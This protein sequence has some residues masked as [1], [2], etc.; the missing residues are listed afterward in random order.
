VGS[1]EHALTELERLAGRPITSVD[2]LLRFIAAT[3]APR[4]APPRA[5]PERALL[6]QGAQLG[7]L[8]VAYLHY[9]FW[10]VSLE[11]AALPA[12]TVFVPIG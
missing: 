1:S 3:S 4:S 2:D 12:L 7:A 11:I 9:Y 6:R 10:E 5:R 8:A